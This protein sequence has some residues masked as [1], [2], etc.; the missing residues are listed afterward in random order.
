MIKEAIYHK[1]DSSYCFAVDENSLVIKL[2]AKKND[3]DEVILCYGDRY[4]PVPIITVYE[5]K[6]SF[7]FSDDLFEYFEIIIKPGFN[8]ICYY[9][10]IIE[11][12]TVIYLSQDIFMEQ[13]PVER[14]RFYL[15]ACICR[16]DLYKR[17]N[18]WQDMIVY[19]IFIDRFNKQNIDAKWYEIPKGSEIYGG[20]LKGIIEKLDYLS[21]LGIN[22]IYLTPIFESDSSH[23]YDIR[24]YY[25]IDS[26]FGDGSIFREL[27]G[28]CHDRGI[29][30][31]LDA[32][33][34]HTSNKFFAFEDIKLNK[35]NSSYYGW[36]IFNSSENYETFG[37]EKKMP[38]VNTM[39]KNAKKYFLEV[40][41]YWI[42]HYNIDGWR[43][44]VANEIDHNFWRDFRKAVKDIKE[45]L[46]IVGE[47]WDGCESYMEGDQFDSIMNYPLRE[48][49]I[50]YMAKEAI[51]T[52]QFDANVNKL[53]SKYKLNM[54]NSLLN[55]MD[56][57]DT[58]RFLYECKGDVEKLRLAM[59]FLMTCIG[60]PM[61]YYGDEAGLTGANDPDCR[62]TIDFSKI[63]ADVFNDY[64]KMIFLRKSL[65]ALRRGSFK[66]ILARE[67][68]YVFKRFSAEQELYIVFNRGRKSCEIELE[69]SGDR[70]VDHYGN[71]E[72]IN[73]KDTF[74]L[75][76]NPFDKYILQSIRS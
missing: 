68:V 38:K 33:F 69:L 66:T 76:T 50:D 57:H 58:S 39:N 18:S 67:D 46:F 41:R 74:R 28:K 75:M 54:R 16:G 25:K 32:V 26:T 22:C 11:G 45:E 13:P 63:N 48:Y 30:V 9:F 49:L 71:K 23:K 17:D 3:L 65:I 19:Q 55:L 70:I 27:V 4:Q 61:I 24:D 40:A 44:D 51:T 59:F 62:R 5:E 73:T 14:N 20:N 56:T 53:F 60:I 47:L 34:N 35:D 64:K 42:E 10:K 29:K 37:S 43:L 12:D 2:R 8:R 52:E 21:E 36:Y 7:S 31:I 6:M 1:S 15:F 72:Y